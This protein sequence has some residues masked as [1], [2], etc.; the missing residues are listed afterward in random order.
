[1]LLEITKNDIGKIVEHS[2]SR[3]WL[4]VLDLISDDEVLCRTK[5]LEAKKFYTFELQPK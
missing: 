3:D 5:S 2:L 4:M 1:M